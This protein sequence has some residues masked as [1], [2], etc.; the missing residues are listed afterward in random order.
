[1]KI[2]EMN[3][4]FPVIAGQYSTAAVFRNTVSS[5]W[6]DDVLASLSP[7]IFPSYNSQTVWWL[8]VQKI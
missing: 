2:L 6:N 1:M 8:P 7:S 4:R 3:I 5:F